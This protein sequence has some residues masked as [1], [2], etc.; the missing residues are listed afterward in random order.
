MGRFKDYAGI[1]R[2]PRRRC[3]LGLEWLEDRVALATFVVTNLGDSG[4][5]SLRQAIALS[6]S[7]PGSNE[8]DF[9][10]GLSGTITLTSGQLTIANNDVTIVGPGSG[11]L[12][13]SGNNASRVFGVNGAITVAISGL[14]IANGLELGGGAGGG[15]SNGGTLTVTNSTLSGNGGSAGGGISNGGTLTIT[16]S[17]FSGNTVS[18]KGGGISNSGTLTVT[19]STLSGN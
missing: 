15:I 8:I 4:D 19:N 17:T 10:P 12:S 13:I 7:T 9:V 18:V 5:G 6:D 2:R 16:N 11:V 3:A 1:S 14:T